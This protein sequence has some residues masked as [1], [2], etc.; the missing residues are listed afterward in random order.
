M[1]TSALYA[2]TCRTI[3]SLTLAW[4]CIACCQGYGGWLTKALSWRLFVPLAR[5]TLSAYLIHPLVMIVFAAS[6]RAPYHFTHYLMFHRLMSFGLTSYL[7][8]IVVAIF[9]EQPL[10]Q[11]EK[12]LAEIFIDSSKN[13]S[14]SDVF[15]Q[16]QLSMSPTIKDG[17]VGDKTVVSHRKFSRQDSIVEELNTQMSVTKT[18]SNLARLHMLP[19]IRRGSSF[20]RRRSVSAEANRLS[21]TKRGNLAKQGSVTIDTVENFDKP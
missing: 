2:A 1:V 9:F 6:I 12:K 14:K 19:A 15:G 4:D 18:S 13:R 5:V 3:W 20:N 21:L 8:A 17:V 16:S 11:F 10:I 7:I